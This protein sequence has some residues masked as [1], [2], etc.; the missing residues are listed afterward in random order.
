VS[1]S[2]STSTNTRNGK[3]SNALSTEESGLFVEDTK[4]S[5]KNLVDIRDDGRTTSKQ[6]NPTTNAGPAEAETER[7][8]ENAGSIKKR[9]VD[10]PVSKKEKEHRG[11][12]ID[13]S[14]SEDDIPYADIT[15]NPAQPELR[16]DPPLVRAATSNYESS[17][18]ADDFDDIEDEL[19]GEEFMERWMEEANVFDAEVDRPSCPICQTSLEG[20]SDS[21]GL[22]DCAGHVVNGL[23]L[24][25]KHHYMSMHV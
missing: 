5:W 1:R 23:I 21:V 24:C 15:K 3:E 22:L 2:A 25:R 16:V 17:A 9:K 13:E 6:V 19:E 11:P 10:P 7:F 8:N 18:V 14:D 20:Q 4:R 12:F